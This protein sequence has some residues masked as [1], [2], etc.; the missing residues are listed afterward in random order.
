MVGD[1]MELKSTGARCWVQP[2]GR[3]YGMPWGCCLV[4]DHD[5]PHC[6][7]AEWNLDVLAGHWS[8]NGESVPMDVH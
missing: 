3:D 6:W 2:W 1:M 5:G 4:I 8:R 7:H